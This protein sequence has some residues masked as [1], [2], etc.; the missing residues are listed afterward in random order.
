MNILFN[1]GSYIE[2]K[3]IMKKVTRNIIV[4]QC[5]Y[6]YWYKLS[7][8][9]TVIYVSPLDDK[10]NK[11]SFEFENCTDLS[12]ENDAWFWR[13]TKMKAQMEKETI[14]I[15]ILMP[16]FIASL[17]KVAM[18]E[19]LNL[20]KEKNTKKHFAHAYLFLEKMGY[21]DIDPLWEATLW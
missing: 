9:S 20:F 5:H 1:T 21:T 4:N 7:C 15:E 17:I 13:L 3:N 10:T 8:E 11:I 6:V 12:H 19:N 16:K 2:G 14:E 18:M